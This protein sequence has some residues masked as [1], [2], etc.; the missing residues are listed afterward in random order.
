[1]AD[2]NGHENSDSDGSRVQNFLVLQE[3]FEAHKADIAQK[4]VDYI[5]NNKLSHKIL[6]RI[7]DFLSDIGDSVLFSRKT[8]EKTFADGTSEKEVMTQFGSGKIIVVM[9]FALVLA[10]LLLVTVGKLLSIL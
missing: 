9:S 8:V 10:V 3:L 5:S 2:A 7:S 4:T 1:M 6:D